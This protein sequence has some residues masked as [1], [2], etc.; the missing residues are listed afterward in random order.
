MTSRR[1][2]DG[3]SVLSTDDLADYD[4][5]SDGHR[6]LES[7]IADLGQ[8]DRNAKDIQEPPP[9]QNARENFYT[10][11]LS[12]EDIQDYV[13][14][15]IAATGAGFREHENGSDEVERKLVRVYVDGKFDGFNIA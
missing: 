12:V 3:S 1:S 9:S 15:A 7:S 5:I 13:K 14:R 10:P 8:F 2:L 4:F 6:S 11:S